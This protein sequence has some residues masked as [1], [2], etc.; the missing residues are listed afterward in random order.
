MTPKE[1]T[2]NHLTIVKE[3]FLETRNPN[4]WINK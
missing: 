3:F 1:I 4:G 2:E